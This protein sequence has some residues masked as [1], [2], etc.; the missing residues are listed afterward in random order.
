MEGLERRR[1]TPV[2]QRSEVG[3]AILLPHPFDDL[4]IGAVDTEDSETPLEMAMTSAV[5][6]VS[7]SLACSRRR[8][9]GNYAMG[10][11]TVYG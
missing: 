4:P 5:V 7:S 9:V 6:P 1:D 11:L 10:I 3:Q 2:R 8:I